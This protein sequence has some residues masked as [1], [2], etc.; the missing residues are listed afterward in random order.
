M[1]LLDIVYMSSE[2]LRERKSRVAL[3]VLGILIGCAAVTGLVSLADGMNNQVSDQLS[4]IG[5]N[6]LFVLPEKAEEAAKAL[7][8]TSILQNHGLTWRDRETVLQTVGVDQITEL[9]TDAGVFTVKGKTYKVQVMGVGY[10]FLEIN[11]DLKL[12]DGRFFTSNDKV[13][14]I[15]GK[16]I[17]QP[18]D[19]DEPVLGVGDRINLV[20]KVNGDQKEITL[21]VVGVLAEHGSV[22]GLNADDILGIPFRTYDQLYESGGTCSIIQAYV[23][24]GESPDLVAEDIK[25]RLGEGY[26]VVSPTAALDVQREVTGTI[27]AVLG[28]IAGISMLVAG[29]GIVNTMAISVNERTKEIGTMKAIGAKNIDILMLFIFEAFYTGIMGGIV[30][31]SIGFAL[32]KIAGGYIGLPVDSNLYLAVIVVSFAVF[33]SLASGAMPAWRASKL[34]PVH[35]LRNE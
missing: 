30:G 23:K 13:G 8:A 26:F 20:V 21:R 27:Q 31:A 7:S 19:E 24:D 12:S 14:V 32:G 18:Q 29:L 5:T 2:G 11:K 15:I 4:V 28:G 22:F 17:A 33:T 34:D 1:K 3:N 6:T 9:S 25:D 35:A 16:N 10:N